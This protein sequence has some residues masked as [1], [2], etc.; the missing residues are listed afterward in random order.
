M[1]KVGQ[2]L[3]EARL[4][5][6][7]TIEEVSQAT[8]IKASFLEAIEESDYQKLPSFAYSQ[9][10]VRNYAR[11]LEFP[12]SEMLAVFRREVE[13]DKNYR[14]LPKGLDRNL[15]S[16]LSK[17]RVGQTVLLAFF[18]IIAVLAYIIFQYRAA[19]FN[20]YLDVSSPKDMT[21]ISSSYVTVMGKTDPNNTLFIND[22]PVSLDS[23]GGFKKT[24]IIFPG[25]TTIVVKVINRFGKQSIVA[26]H[27]KVKSS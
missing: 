5:K 24:L 7:L 13:E 27:I 6:G 26:R 10:F 18:V 2:R 19:I 8:K 4:Q 25:D 16:P 23:S 17:F 9:G 21:V 15:Q 12:E 14:V 3:K 22:Q 20:P 1:L 11:F